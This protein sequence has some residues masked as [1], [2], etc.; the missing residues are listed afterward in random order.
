MSVSFVVM[1]TREKGEVRS[2]GGI[3]TTYAKYR[4]KSNEFRIESG[5][6]HVWKQELGAY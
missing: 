4:Y 1:Y 6:G 5:F 3:L 2:L